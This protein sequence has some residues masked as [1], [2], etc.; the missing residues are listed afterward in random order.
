MRNDGK[1]Q[2]GAP[3]GLHNT[4]PLRELETLNGDVRVPERGKSEKDGRSSP[5]W[6]NVF[7]YFL[8]I[9]I[10]LAF[11]VI[12]AVADLESV[13]DPPGLLLV[14]NTCFL[15]L[16]P[17]LVAYFAMKGYLSSGSISLIM[18]AAGCLS[19][20]LGSIL[21]G[22]MPLTHL[23][24]SGV[25]AIHN[26]SAL[27]SSL[28][29]VLGVASALVGL[30]PQ[31]DRRRKKLTV[32]SLFIGISVFAVLVTIAN[33]YGVGP[34]F[35]VQ[36]S[37]P[38]PFRQTVLGGATAMFLVSGVLLGTMYLRSGSRFIF[39]YCMALFL[40][41]E[42]LLCIFI[43]KA[44]GS[45]IGW[46][47][48]GLQYLAGIYLLVAIL[49][50]RS[51]LAVTGLSLDV[52]IAKLL[53]HH[54]E[55]LIEQRTEELA[56]ANQELRHENTERVKVQDALQKAKADLEVRVRER[57]AEL[58]M[59][60]EELVR[61]IDERKKVEQVLQWTAQ[62]LKTISDC[63]QALIRAKE[64]SSLLPEIC[65]IV[66]EVGG[67]PAA[68]VGF[69]QDAE[70]R[71]VRLVA[72]WGLEGPD[73]K[74]LE[75]SWEDIEQGSGPTGTAIRTGTISVLRSAANDPATALW[76]D[77]IK[78]YGV[79]SLI[80]FPLVVQRQVIGAMTIAAARPD[81][82]DEERVKLLEELAGDVAY[83]IETLRTRVA[84]WK[85]EET[86]RDSENRL[87]NYLN[88]INEMGLGIFVVDRNFK[89]RHMNSTMVR[90]F[91]DHLGKVCYE[92]V[93][94][95]SEPCSYCQM[96]NVVNESQVVHYEPSTAD[97][98]IFS[99]VA[100]PVRENDGSI[101]KMEIIAD[102]TDRKR[103]EERLGRISSLVSD[104]AYSCIKEPSGA[105]SIDWL[106]GGAE[107][108]T[109]YSVDDL[110]SVGCWRSLVVDDDL[111]VFDSCVTGLAPGTTGS[112]EL[113]L[114]HKTAGIVWIAS[115]AECVLVPE[116]SDRMR[117]Y[118]GLV[119]ITDRK[120]SE[121]LMRMRLTL[122]EFSAS[123]SL[124]ELLQKALDEIGSLTDSPIGFYHFMSEDE[125]TIS[126]Q[127][128][129][130]RTVMEFCQ[131]EGKERHYAVDRAGVWVDAIKER[132]PV[133]HND[134]SALPHRKGLP[135]GHAAVIREL[136]V[137]IMR[138]DR[139]V[140]ILGIGNKPTDYSEKDIRVVSY[141]ADVAWEITQ[142]KRTEEALKETGQQYRTLFEDS[143]DGV[144]SVF[145]D[146]TITDTNSSF[147]EL[148]GYTREEMIGKDIRELYLDPAHRVGFQKEIEKK[149]FVKDYEI[150]FR[151]RD[152]TELDCLVTSSVHS[153]RDGGIAGYR[154][155]VRDLTA[156]KAL[157]RQLQQAQK[158]EAVGTLAG[159][160]AHDFNNI[161][162]VVLGFSEIIL[163]GKGKEDPEYED[164]EKVL[165]AGKKGA[166]LV[167]RLLTFSRKTE[168][169]PRPLNLNHQ[170]Q[171]VEAI[172]E[173]T[174]PKIIKIDLTLAH[175]LAA[176]NADP[177]QI[178]QILMNL[179]VNA[180]DAMPEGGR[181]I[182]ETAN[183][184]LDEG[185]CTT[186]LGS[187]PGDYVLLTVSD[188]G[189]GMD[190]NTLE[191]IFEP[192]FSTK[193][194]GKGTGLGLALVYGIVKQHNGYVTCYSEP[195]VG[196]TFKLYFPVTEMQDESIVQRKERELPGGSET[197]FVVDDDDLVREL[198]KRILS[199]AGYT[200]LTAA[201]GREALQIYKKKSRT[202]SLTV[203]DL[204]MPE[205]DGRQCLKALLKQNPG[206]KVLVAS[207][208]SADG[209]T[210]AALEGGAKGFVSKPF[211]MGQLLQTVRKVLDGE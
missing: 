109:G 202:I 62:A 200:V 160:I 68:W 26:C 41:A 147:C 90:W 204:I 93:A 38:T 94:G 9:P 154:G 47:G 166:D 19:L 145:R 11:I 170:I 158:M 210:K 122:L 31:R 24:V 192:F 134:Y 21:A 174:I 74:K 139:I 155:I 91:G 186:H 208:Y 77:E 149:G 76:R 198:A 60:N 97:G 138:S 129:S 57:T 195:G 5:D 6:R 106:T 124:D 1:G 8:P 71:T 153:G 10:S 104:I 50:A 187:K 132:R 84:H 14:L 45:P 152:G 56:R 80:S 37:G 13:F 28:F 23:G 116:S 136:V 146:G 203:L 58:R 7:L 102:I 20:G 48:R 12:L 65:R 128:W 75:M 159:G 179:A 130:T 18:L 4:N 148:F 3:G 78:K 185:Y 35:F 59:S 177:T 111:P 178:D 46:L 32:I 87:S 172:L 29:Q 191:H 175:G 53:R 157:H 189:E 151:K 2:R 36:G 88:S 73:A 119:D 196:T 197:I 165:S 110:K 15:S 118:G 206:A 40:I 180:R 123:H 100:A 188:T 86:L 161:L 70:F 17:F 142:R 156:R 30:P 34:V 107:R 64:E 126:L 79:G 162:Q 127:A 205:M 33:V 113:R 150:K 51:E 92:S 52:G 125:K 181:L 103:A 89:V 199:R 168:I 83:G 163:M 66:V 95:L 171:R 39:S 120:I 117:L 98:R 135:E 144:Y 164:L 81:A 112:C 114:R 43:Q 72:Q 143:I 141:I 49:E 211:D 193:P 22:F 85:A 108:L 190:K 201:N 25:V 55:P 194:A 121:E 42:G 105:Y 99:V 16:L 61:E 101:S 82:F 173:R 44:V 140:A 183:V 131:A 69:S 67:Y 133:I 137:P 96:N 169:N 207:G 63:N 167:Q 27:L 54:L 184:T 182:L 115:F 209:P 176:V